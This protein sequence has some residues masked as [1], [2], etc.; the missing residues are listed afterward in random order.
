MAWLKTLADTY[1]VYSEL[2]GVIKNDQ[3]VLLP[4]S[5]STFNAQIE[6]TLDEEGNFLGS[7]KL[8]KGPDVVTIIPVTEDSASR[9]NGNFP[10]PLCD[11]LCYVAGDYALYTG[12]QKK[13][14]YYESY[15]EQLQD[16]AES[17]D[18]HPMVQTIC[19]Y[20]QKKSL[21]HDLIQDHTLE[22]NESGRLTDNV[23]L[24]GSGQTGANVRFIVYGNDTP[25]VWENQ[26]IYEV[27]DRYYQK[28]AGQTELCYVSGEMG[29]C[30]EK[31][32]SKIRNSGDKAKLIS[33]NDESGFTYRGRFASKNQAV[34]VGY[35]VS[36][37]AHNALKWLIQKQGYTRDGS[38]V[39]CWMSN[40]DMSVPDMMKDSIHAYEDLDD[41]E[42]DFDILNDMEAE[43]KNKQDTGKYFAEQFKLAVCGY[44]GKI[45]VDDHIAVIALDAATTGRM[46]IC[47][48]DEMG[49]KQYMDALLKWQ[50]HCKWHRYITV[51]KNDGGKK[52]IPCE[53]SP[54]PRDMALA[55]FGTQ[56]SN[57]LEADSKLIRAV[58][59]RLLPY[60]TG[61]GRKIPSDI[62]RAA[63]RRA[64]MPQSM[65]PFVWYNDVLC[66]ACAMIRFN[67]EKEKGGRTMDKFLEDNVNDRNVLF[68]RLLAVYDLMEQRAM[69]QR[70]ENGKVKEGRT[71]NARRYWNAFSSRP[72]K[73]FQTIKQNMIP[74]EKKLKSFQLKKFEEWTEEIMVHLAGAGFDNKP[75][76]EMYL[77]A[78]Y[79][80]TEYM[81][82]ELHKKEQ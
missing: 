34:S 47:Y 13:K 20:L 9:G 46:S 51:E 22:L 78:Y 35:V 12:D 6:V 29:T 80:Q 40:R 7:K 30:S 52:N 19:K 38:A 26:E 62:V 41:F 45:K 21:I 60:I 58:T 81:K 66:V 70:D 42:F 37:K 55:A 28:K 71:T 64:S 50:E 43:N 82:Q 33:G 44:A 32:P 4:L 10:H 48:Y 16:W 14:E 72:A 68:G 3:P 73:T 24:Q 74:Y 54:S 1:D 63:A 75:L 39:V 31:H 49:G 76:S 79:L 67:Y 11:K 59:T 17:E 69:S 36:Q 27:F 53:C 2:A 5:H 25:R 65:N 15:M 61:K 23:K 18:T 8:D 56:R 77:P 57:W